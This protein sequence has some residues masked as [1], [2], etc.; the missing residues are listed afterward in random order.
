MGCY[1]KWWLLL[2]D[3]SPFLLRVPVADILFP[4]RQ[5]LLYTLSRPESYRLNPK[6]P[7]PK[8]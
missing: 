7:N 4:L 1:R 5:K 3:R 6:T 8:P 2:W